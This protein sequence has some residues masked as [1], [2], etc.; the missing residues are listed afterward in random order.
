MPPSKLSGRELFQAVAVV[1][2]QSVHCERPLP[3]QTTITSTGAM[4]RPSW[5]GRSICP[6]LKL[7]FTCKRPIL[8]STCGSPLLLRKRF[9]LADDDQL[10]G[11]TGDR[12][13]HPGSASGGRAT[14]R[15]NR[16]LVRHTS[17][18]W[19]V[20]SSRFR[21]RLAVTRTVFGMHAC[22]RLFAVIIQRATPLP[23]M[24]NR[25]RAGS[26]ILAAAPDIRFQYSSS[27]RK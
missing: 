20:A 9:R 22:L 13:H 6:V 26:S 2:R 21:R 12:L 15:P 23:G 1:K 19:S 7:S 3:S 24:Q 11:A 16:Q 4:N 14:F 27:A 8:Q 25:N 5:S 10:L 18:V 17:R